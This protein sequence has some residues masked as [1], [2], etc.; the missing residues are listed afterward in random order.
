MTINTTLHWLVSQTMFVVEI[1][2]AEITD[3][4][5]YINYSLLS[6]MDYLV[7][8]R[9]G[10]NDLLFRSAKV[11]DAIDGKFGQIGV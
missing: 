11:V 4:E 10:D 7:D 1:F 6:M 3:S 2:G 9:F 8:S 5:F